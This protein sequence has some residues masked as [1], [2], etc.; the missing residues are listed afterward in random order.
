MK[1]FTDALSKF[2]KETL[3]ENQIVAYNLVANIQKQKYCS[4]SGRLLDVCVGGVLLV[5]PLLLSREETKLR[6]ENTAVNVVKV[7]TNSQKARRSQDAG[8]GNVRRGHGRGWAG[9]EG[10]ARGLLCADQGDTGTYSQ[11]TIKDVNTAFYANLT[12]SWPPQK[13]KQAGEKEGRKFRGL[14]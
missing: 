5:L 2:G 12:P 11:R 10:G 8:G 3:S 7:K 1:S 14:C 9:V 4:Y 6:F 13:G